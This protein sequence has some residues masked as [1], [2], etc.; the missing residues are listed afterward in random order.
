MI[1][2]YYILQVLDYTSYGDYKMLSF[3]KVTDFD[4]SA[5]FDEYDDDEEIYEP[6]IRIHGRNGRDYI[7]KDGEYNLIKCQLEYYK[8]GN[9]KKQFLKGGKKARPL[10]TSKARKNVRKRAKWISRN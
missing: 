2:D 10:S 7:R 4:E 1:K 3:C 6:A 8:N 5:H 9:I